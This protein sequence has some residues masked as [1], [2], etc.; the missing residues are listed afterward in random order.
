MNPTLEATEA[1]RVPADATVCHY[2]ELTGDAK[3]AFPEATADG[4][5]TIGWR[6]AEQFA[7]ID[8]VKFT[9]YYRIAITG[10]GDSLDHTGVSTT[11]AEPGTGVPTERRDRHGEP[12][13][14]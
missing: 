8:V 2:D 3:H 5:T 7:S 13:L 11:T 9:S 10:F 6:T 4:T 12:I 1:D 14:E